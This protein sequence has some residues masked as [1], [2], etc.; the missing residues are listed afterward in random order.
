MD[1]RTEIEMLSTNERK[2]IEEYKRKYVLHDYEP[3]SA[4]Y[5]IDDKRLDARPSRTQT[6]KIS[7]VELKIDQSSPTTTTQSLAEDQ[8]TQVCTTLFLV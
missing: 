7:A 4:S 6:R 5:S 1:T 8:T 2:L 3:H